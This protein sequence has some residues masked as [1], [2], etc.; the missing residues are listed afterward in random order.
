MPKLTPARL[1]GLYGMDTFTAEQL[2]AKAD[3]YEGQID[4][5]KNTDDPKYLLRWAKRV[6]K[7]ALQKEKSREQK[8]NEK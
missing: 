2:H 5:P 4:N 8:F 1:D 6:R 7:L 3:W